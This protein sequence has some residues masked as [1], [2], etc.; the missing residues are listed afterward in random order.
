[1]TQRILIRRIDRIRSAT[2]V[3]W[4]LSPHGKVLAIYSAPNLDMRSLE[5]LQSIQY[6]MIAELVEKSDHG[7]SVVPAEFYI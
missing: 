1:M 4:L 3:N 7:I 2:S 6:E 5:A